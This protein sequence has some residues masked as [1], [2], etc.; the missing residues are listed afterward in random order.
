MMRSV[1][2]VRVGREGTINTRGMAYNQG[3]KKKETSKRVSEGESK[4]KKTKRIITTE[5]TEDK[6]Q[7]KSNN[8]T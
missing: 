6:A 3:V 8:G 5:D 2:Q 4:T 7:K 1:C